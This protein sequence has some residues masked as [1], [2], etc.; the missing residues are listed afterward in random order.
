MP[1]LAF[2]NY[3]TDAD[4]QDPDHLCADN[5]LFRPV[6][7]SDQYGSADP[8]DAVLVRAVDAVQRLGPLGSARPAREQR[9]ALLQRPERRRGATLA[10]RPRR[11][12]PAVHRR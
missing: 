6:T 10:D 2:G 5:E 3:V 9:P 8:V 1:T 7:G 12:A 4:T 11:T